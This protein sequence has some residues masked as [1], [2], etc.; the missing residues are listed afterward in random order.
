VPSAPQPE[1]ALVNWPA[2][3][4][5]R[6]E[7]AAVG[8]PCLLL[9]SGDSEPPVI[10]GILEDWIRVPADERDL[11]ARLRRLH[12]LVNPSTGLPMVDDED[13][14]HHGDRW[15]GLSAS[16]ATLARILLVSYRKLVTRRS[17]EE[18]LLQGDESSRVIDTQVHR[19]RTRI[20]SL[21][22]TVTA[23]RGRGYVLEPRWMAAETT[24][25]TNR[26]TGERP[27]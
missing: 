26:Q 24:T 7:L 19:L 2:Q 6:R 4:D 17:L 13:L 14:F 20:T 23:V 9:V 18:A 10:D 15:V 22:F 21:G 3:N 1:V 12:L 11:Y 27:S 5:R 16:E 8:A 25:G